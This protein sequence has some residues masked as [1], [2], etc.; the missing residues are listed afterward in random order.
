MTNHSATIVDRLWN[1]CNVLRDAG[2]WAGDYQQYLGLRHM[3]LD[4]LRAVA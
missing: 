4:R 3:L 1:Y 2:L